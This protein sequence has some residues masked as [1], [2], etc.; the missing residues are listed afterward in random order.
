MSQAATL[1]LV[2]QPL[3]ATTPLALDE[4]WNLVSY[5]PE[6]EITVAEALA[7]IDGKYTAVL[8]FHD[9]GAVSYYTELPPEFNDLRCL[10]PGHGYWIK[11]SEAVT[12]TYTIT[13]TCAGE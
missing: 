1:Q 6:M 7:S 5:L 4:G 3:A 10:R 12:L 11:A 2:G 9:G 13:G 8:G